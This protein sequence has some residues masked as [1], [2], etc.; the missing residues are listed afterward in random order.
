MSALIGVLLA[1]AC[2]AA[3][4]GQ[5]EAAGTS[6]DPVRPAPEGLTE[7]TF[8][9]DERQVPYVVA[10][11]AGYD[12]SAMVQLQVLLPGGSGQAAPAAAGWGPA[13]LEADAIVAIPD[14]VGVEEVR[15]LIAALV[16]EYCVDPRRVGLIGSS[17]SG[18]FTVRL[19]EASDDLVAAM[20]IGIGSF[21]VEG[22]E[23]AIP[24][25]AWTG[26]SDRAAVD[27]SVESW[28]EVNGCDPTPEERTA[29]E[30]T[31]FTYGGCDAP[32]EYHVVSG[33][34][35]QV[36]NHRCPVESIYCYETPSIDLLQ[37][38]AAFFDANPLPI[39]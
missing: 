6:C 5:T 26:D 11:P 15:G 9:F 38:A 33:M 13:L 20:A 39:G 37:S 19:A 27:R 18:R 31:T 34:R 24:L 32:I 17:S 21:P 7:Y 28:V 25:L 23:R 35:H 3:D 8:A 2:G 1:V 29:G 10:V 16:E 22:G 14:R 30:L 36:P 4:D 12:G